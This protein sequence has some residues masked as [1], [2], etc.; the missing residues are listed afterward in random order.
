MVT[1]KAV[2]AAAKV[3]AVVATKVVAAAAEVLF[4]IDNGHG[5]G[6]AK[7]V[8]VNVAAEVVSAASKVVAEVLCV[9]RRP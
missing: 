3:V 8:V 9:E 5:D 7:F 2:D 6:A 1:A 4:A